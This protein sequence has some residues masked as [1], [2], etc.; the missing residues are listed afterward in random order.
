M[1]NLDEKQVKSS[2]FPNDPPLSA[3]SPS[4]MPKNNNPWRWGLGGLGLGSVIALGL[5]SSLSGIS[6]GC[7]F[8]DCRV[9]LKPSPVLPPK[10]P[11]RGTSLS[12]EALS[13]SLGQWQDSLQSLEQ[14]APGS[15]GYNLAQ[16]RLKAY[17]GEVQQLRQRQQA[18]KK[19]QKYYQEAQAQAQ[20]AQ[21]N[22]TKKQWSLAVNHWQAA[23][24]TLKQVPDQGVWAGHSQVLIAAYSSLL[25]QAQF[26]LQQALR[27]Q[28]V[29]RDLDKLCNQLSKNCEFRIDSQRIQVQLTAAYLEQIWAAALQAKVEGNL[30]NQVSVL[31]HIAR[32]EQSLQ[33]ISN[34]AGVPL[35]LYHAQGT[36]LTEY[37]PLP[38]GNV[39]FSQK[40]P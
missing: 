32:L 16:E 14:I 11:P 10:S 20:L 9:E 25:R 39:S 35:E 36:K 2:I 23:L 40:S 3:P 1:A 24:A 12:P 27:V 28:A 29:Q 22:I 19:A 34:Q 26:G 37:R 7:L 30:Q 38:Q 33:H 31:N 4:L 18:E 17:R 21:E 15:D 6:P 5:F 13:Q 8:Q